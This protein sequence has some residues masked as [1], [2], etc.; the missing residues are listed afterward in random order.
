MDDNLQTYICC[1]VCF[2]SYNHTIVKPLFLSCGHILCN[3]CFEKWIMKS[4]KCP[5]C[6]TVIDTVILN[7]DYIVLCEYISSAYKLEIENVTYLNL[8]PTHV[9]VPNKSFGMSYSIIP[10]LGILVTNV[11]KN[12]PVSSVGIIKGDVIV[13]INGNPITSLVMF[14][15]IEQMYIQYKIP[16]CVNIQDKVIK[17]VYSF[18]KNCTQT[19]NQII[20]IHE[21]NMYFNKFDMIFAING[22]VGSELIK[23]A[24]K[25]GLFKYGDNEIKYRATVVLNKFKQI[26]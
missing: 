8:K 12:G 17:Y 11:T 9:I 10:G 26:I 6:R 4:Y 20:K 15:N 13:R 2:R 1:G 16:L 23:K 22:V 14:R 3:D 5:F 25:M 18:P 21:D 19:N 7:K 24:N